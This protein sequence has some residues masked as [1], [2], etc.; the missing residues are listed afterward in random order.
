MKALVAFDAAMRRNSFSL[1]AKDLSVTP[2]AIGQQIQKLE[3]WLGLPLFIREV[4]QVRPTADALGYWNAIQPALAQIRHAS[5]A[6]QR[7]RGNEVRLS[8]PPGFSAKWFA[9][10]MAQFVRRHPEVAL[11]LSASSA[12]VDFERDAFDL[13][14]RYFDGHDPHLAATL[15]YADEARAF[16]SPDY[17]ACLALRQPADLVRATLLHS[18]LHPH[19]RDW[20]S[21]HAGL[22]ETRIAAIHGIHFDHALVAIESAR[23]GQGIMLGSALLV[24]EELASGA[25]IEPFAQRLPLNKGFYVVHRRAAPLRPAAQ[26]LKDWL[27]EA[28]A[29]AVD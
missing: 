23:Q 19:W 29:P 22:D 27:I 5:Q 24:E 2:G 6:A 15:L 26:A 4:R 1:A 20:L 9:P 28:A 8:M 11:H 7:S 25:L 12:L 21:R 14:I 17:A 10:R 18:T 3:A 13:G 16:C